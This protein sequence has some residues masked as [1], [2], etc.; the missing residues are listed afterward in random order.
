VEHPKLERGDRVRYAGSNPMVPR[1][2]E[3]V[4]VSVLRSRG[5]A[6]ALVDF[7]GFRYRAAAESLEKVDGQ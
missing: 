1:G 7:T 5:R 3:G 6:V 2:T 4:V